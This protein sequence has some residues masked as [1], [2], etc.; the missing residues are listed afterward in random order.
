MKGVDLIHDT[1]YYSYLK[2]SAF[3]DSPQSPGLFFITN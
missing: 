1:I 2:Y 3:S